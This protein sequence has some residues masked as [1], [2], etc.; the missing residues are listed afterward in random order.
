MVNSGFLLTPCTYTNG[1]AVSIGKMRPMATHGPTRES[2]RFFFLP[3]K[4]SPSVSHRCSNCYLGFKAVGVGQL[5]CDLERLVGAQTR[6]LQRPA[7]GARMSPPGAAVALHEYNELALEFQRS[8]SP[9]PDPVID[10]MDLST[11]GTREETDVDEIGDPGTGA[12]LRLHHSH[13]SLPRGGRTSCRCS[14][15]AHF[16]K[17]QSQEMCEPFVLTDRKSQRFRNGTRA[18]SHIRRGHPPMKRNCHCTKA[19]RFSTACVVADDARRYHKCRR[20]VDETQVPVI[21]YSPLPQS[22]V[23]LLSLPAYT[24]PR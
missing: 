24:F 7:T 9:F 10:P 13:P 4:Y 3:W 11:R 16:R 6:H 8:C 12:L 17:L 5:H 14:R 20:R 23:D 1:G 2:G 15:G 18:P 21:R 19:I 22:L